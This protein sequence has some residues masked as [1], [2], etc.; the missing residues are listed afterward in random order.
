MNLNRKK[1]LVATLITLVYGIVFSYLLYFP[2]QNLLKET[3]N[4]LVSTQNSIKN[5]QEELE[6][7]KKV[8]LLPEDTK[9]QQPIQAQL[10]IETPTLLKDITKEAEKLNVSILLFQPLPQEQKNR[11]HISPYTLEVQG[12]FSQVLGFFD[13]ISDPVK[14]MSIL[15]IQIQTG[16]IENDHQ[17]IKARAQLTAYQHID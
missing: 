1:I 13:K 4:Q 8:V 11:L 3:N 2:S 12:K 16:P 5:L 10:K 6:K 9:P 14:L 7:I 17:L 15:N